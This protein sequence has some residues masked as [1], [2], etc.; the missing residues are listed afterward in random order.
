MKKSIFALV[1]VLLVFT[2][3]AL[4][5]LAADGSS[6]ETA[7]R[8]T[9]H[10]FRGSSHN[11]SY[12]DLDYVTVPIDEPGQS[13]YFVFTTNEA[14]R[15]SPSVQG[16]AIYS[17]EYFDSGLNPF[18]GRPEEFEANTTYYIRW[19][20]TARNFNNLNPDMQ[21]VSMAIADM[22]QVVPE[23]QLPLWLVLGLFGGFLFVVLF[24]YRRYM[25]KNYDLNPVE[26]KPLLISMGLSMAYMLIMM[27]A[28]LHAM[29]PIFLCMAPGVVIPT[30]KLLKVTK[31]PKIL[32]IHLILMLGFYGLMG[33]VAMFVFFLV[34]MAAV[35]VGGFFVL[36][37][38][39]GR[40]G[41]GGQKSNPYG[42]GIDKVW[43][44]NGYRHK[45]DV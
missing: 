35:V 26:L 2:M 31:K 6:F 37:M 4:P 10:V 33:L 7:I 22:T 27:I 3:F 13:V 29:W 41:G 42:P 24:P 11:V 25:K 8:I 34:M 45:D 44:S 40:G 38:V 15:Y 17:M 21:R 1:L 36:K 43:T 18:D 32:A 19:T 39:M 28:S 20:S 9:P 14:G 16:I 23:R 5:A 12:E 30:L